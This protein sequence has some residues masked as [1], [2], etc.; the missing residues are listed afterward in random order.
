M[1]NE[2]M[3]QTKTRKVEKKTPQKLKEQYMVS[4]WD[5]TH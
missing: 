1:E 3:K 4:F 5:T 2:E